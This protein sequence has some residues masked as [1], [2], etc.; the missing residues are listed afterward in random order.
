MLIAHWQNP[1]NKHRQTLCLLAEVLVEGPHLGMGGSGEHFSHQ[2]I[3]LVGLLD[4]DL[5]LLRWRL[6][7]G[8][9][10]VVLFCVL[11]SL[12]SC[13][14]SLEGV[15]FIPLIPTLTSLLA[16]GGSSTLA[17]STAGLALYWSTTGS[18]AT[19]VG[20]LL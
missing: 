3:I 2:T 13:F 9:V 15:S 20:L 1:T 10:L 4:I 7:L 6:L 11:L 12:A 17:P 14:D 19:I 5:V 18:S 8:L 16:A